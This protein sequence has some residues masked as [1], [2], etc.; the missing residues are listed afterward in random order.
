MSQES[1]REIFLDY[2]KLA[3]LRFVYEETGADPGDGFPG[4]ASPLLKHDPRFTEPESR[5]VNWLKSLLKR[6]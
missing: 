1:E 5:L 3:I 4:P 2:E 6:K